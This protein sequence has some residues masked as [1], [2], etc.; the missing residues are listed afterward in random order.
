ME[1]VALLRI[2]WRFR[3]A[4]VLGG[5]VAIGL[6]YM[7]MRGTTSHVGVA[8]MRVMLDTPTSQIVDVDPTGAATLE[9]RASLL[10]DLMSTDPMQQ[11]IARGMGI[12]T[13]DLVVSVP[14]LS[15]PVVPAPLPRA[16]LE[17]AAAVPEP[18][19]LA[20]R[21]ATL[22]P[23]VGINSRAPS[24][25]EA[26]RLATVAADALGSSSATDVTADVQELV[27]NDV[28]PVHTREVVNG[29]RPTIAVVAAVFF[30]GLWCASIALAALLSRRRRVSPLMRRPTGLTT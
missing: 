16:G 14:D 6:G 10:A 18:Y 3:I 9:W 13:D 15:V 28:G 27:V 1:L 22:L 7:A 17:A 26:A 21:P 8:S 20:I 2:L 23:I 24:R 12:P 30:F 19:Q 25:A 11:R 4:V 5:L 29:P